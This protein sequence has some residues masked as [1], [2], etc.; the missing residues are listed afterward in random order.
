MRVLELP[1]MLRKYNVE[2]VLVAGWQTRG[3]EFPTRP[4]GALRHWTAG[5]TRLGIPSL[6]ILTHGRSDLPGPLCAVGQERAPS[7]RDDRAYVV[8]SGKANHAGDG[9]WNGIRGNYKLLGLEI[10]W[11]GPTET[12]SSRRR[13]VSERIMA[14][15]LDCCAGTSS[16]DAAEHREYALPPGRKIDTNLSGHDLRRRLAI[17]RTPAP[18]PTEPE[19][20]DEEAPV[21]LAKKT[22]TAEVFLFEG[23]RMTHVKSRADVDEIS[24][25]AG[26]PSE[27]AVVSDATWALLTKGRVRIS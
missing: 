26:I 22:G 2:P 12:F 1:D 23:G 21:F 4:D 19:L 15:L 8:A 13:D 17:L 16:A 11:A 14:A 7:D 20:I 25:A 18:P 10:E 5:S 24:A 9:L 6:N 3:H 27:E